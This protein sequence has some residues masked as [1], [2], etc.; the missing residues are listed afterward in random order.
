MAMVFSVA[1][2]MVVMLKMLGVAKLHGTAPFA[3]HLLK[4]AKL[5]TSTFHSDLLCSGLFHSMRKGQLADAAYHFD[6]QFGIEGL[7]SRVL[8]SW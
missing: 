2:I 8:P 1:L 4:Q 7:T 5:K 3:S 6:W